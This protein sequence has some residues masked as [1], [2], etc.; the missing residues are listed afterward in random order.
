MAVVFLKEADLVADMG[1]GMA[2]AEVGL[3]SP[4]MMTTTTK[5]RAP[6]SFFVFAQV[7]GKST[8]IASQHHKQTGSHMH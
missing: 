8:N 3:G 7:F 4:T 1:T 5:W 6:E 2:T